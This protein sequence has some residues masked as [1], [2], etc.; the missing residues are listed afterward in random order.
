MSSNEQLLEKIRKLS[1]DINRINSVLSNLNSNSSSSSN[2]TD[3][4]IKYKFNKSNLNE[5]SD[6]K[7]SVIDNYINNFNAIIEKLKS[8]KNSIVHGI[9]HEQKDATVFQ[10]KN[11]NKNILELYNYLV[12]KIF[13]DS[14]IQRGSSLSKIGE[15]NSSIIKYLPYNNSL[16]AHANIYYKY[17][18]GTIICLN[19]CLNFINN[20]S[21]NK[22]KK[23]N[24][25]KLNELFIDILENKIKYISTSQQII[26]NKNSTD[27]VKILSTDI[28]KNA[29]IID[30]I[31]YIFNS[32]KEIQ[33]KD[34]DSSVNDN[35]ISTD[36]EQYKTENIST[37]NLEIP[38]SFD[39]KMSENF[40]SS[41][42][43]SKCKITNEYLPQNNI[44]QF[45]IKFIIDD[46][47]L[48]FSLK[49]N[50]YYCEGIVKNNNLR[51]QFII[52]INNNEYYINP[53]IVSYNNLS[54][55]L[56]K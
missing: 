23:L 15:T 55:L 22:D 12:K 25:N 21:M 47:N 51:K 30:K 40:D 39:Y 28:T 14:N 17:V 29:N 13:N 38:I 4:K 41:H 2:L 3:P 48:K 44:N 35:Y 26:N 1:E 45:L 37:D 52:N 42:S 54:H 31:K 32:A 16:H 36:E 20:I 5:I 56:V 24:N 50:Y 11:D 9:L 49:I 8:K 46:I 18:F 43:Y 53:N 10:F 19:I 6:E 27:I 33:L 7:N 34:T